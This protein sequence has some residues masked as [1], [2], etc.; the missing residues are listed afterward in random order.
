MLY[1]LNIKANTV[2]EPVTKVKKNVVIRNPTIKN[3]VL[4][5]A[6]AEEIQNSK[7]HLFKTY[8]DASFYVE[9]SVY[10]TE[11]YESVF[12]IIETYVGGAHPRHDIK[13]WVIHKESNAFLTLDDLINK[14]ENFLKD[15]SQSLRGDLLLSPRITNATWLMEGTRPLKENY[16][17]FVLEEN[18]IIFIFKEYQIAPYASGLIK[19]SYDYF[20]NE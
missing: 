3:K 18:K 13:T 14:D 10:E 17:N 11:N 1:Q 16:E 9:G 8:Q 15:V 19:A 20:W 7:A 2:F 6:V 4:Q 12:L 5:E